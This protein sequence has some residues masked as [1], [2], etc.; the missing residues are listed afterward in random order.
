MQGAAEITPRFGRVVARGGVGV[1]HVS[2]DSCVHAVLISQPW[3]VGW[4]LLSRSSV[5]M[6][7]RQ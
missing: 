5:K 2:L 4:L 6:A 3:F 7:V 1:E